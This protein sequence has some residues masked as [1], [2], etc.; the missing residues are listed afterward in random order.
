MIQIGGL[1]IM[2]FSTVA[3]MA[4]GRR[5]SL[6]HE[7]VV[8]RL[9]STEDRGT[10]H[11][12]ARRILWFTVVSE[13]FGAGALALH[14]GLVGEAWGSAIGRGIFTSISAFCNAGLALQ[15][16]SLIPY[17]HSP[18]VLH[19]VGALIIGGGLSPVAVLAIPR[20][21]RRTTAP[22]SAQIRLCLAMTALLLV[23]GTAF[24]LAFEWNG[25]LAGLSFVDRLHNAWFQSVTLRTAGFNSVNL[26]TI[27]PETTLL[28]LVWMFIGGSPGGTAGGVKTTTVGVLLLSVLR[29]FRGQWT[30]HVFGRRVPERTRVKAI[31]T[32]TLAVGSAVLASIA[33][34]LTQELGAWEA[35]FEV[36][37]ALGTL[38]LSIGGTAHLDG[39]GKAIIVL[40]MFTGRVGGLTL[41]MFLADR[42]APVEVVVRRRTSMSAEPD[43]RSR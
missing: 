24:F 26:S 23:G 34:L 8:A 22:I 35:V 18:F 28:V 20:L 2:T 15:S 27:R 3:L 19:V 4:L 10:L 31:I 38:G 5:L 12:T 36:V 1:G 6:K 14:F 33:I 40:C 39:I 41:L 11:I 13:T 32:V 25:T 37:S 16:D 7:G 21:I 17:Q 29:V 30:L 42:R 9:I 43:W